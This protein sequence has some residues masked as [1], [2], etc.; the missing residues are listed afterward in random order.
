MKD[1]STLQ[2]EIMAQAG[3]CPKVWLFRNSVGQGWMGVTV[4]YRNNM[5]ALEHPRRITFGWGEGSS[6]LLGWREIIV[7]PDMVGKP[8]AQL[9]ALE[10]KKPGGRVSKQQ[11]RFIDTVQRSG[12]VASVVYSAEDAIK[13]VRHG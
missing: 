12:G 1:E 7:T 2:A 13:A 4:A 10:V 8:I 9:V 5:V 3:I 6:D 11:K